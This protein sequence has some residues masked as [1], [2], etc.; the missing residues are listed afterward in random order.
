[1]I[2]CCS[3]A[4]LH[5]LPL[6]DHLLDRTPDL[7]REGF[8]QRSTICVAFCWS[9]RTCSMKRGTGAAMAAANEHVAIRVWYLEAN[10]VDI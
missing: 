1:M 7:K 10:S 6:T 5:V 4:R 8:F 9:N 3:E 2:G